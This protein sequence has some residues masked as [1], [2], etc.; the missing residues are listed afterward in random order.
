MGLSPRG[1]TGAGFRPKMVQL[2]FNLTCYCNNVSLSEWF[3]RTVVQASHRAAT[4]DPLSPMLFIIV[5]EPLQHLLQLASRDGALE[6]C[7]LSHV[8]ALILLRSWKIS[9]AQLSPSRAPISACRGT[10]DR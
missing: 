9:D 4:G 2:D 7:T 8:M 5:M 1:F 6:Q 10:H 3:K